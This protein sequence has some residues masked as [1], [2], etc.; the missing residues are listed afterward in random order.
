E[1]LHQFLQLI[2]KLDGLTLAHVRRLHADEIGALHAVW[3]FFSCLIE[4]VC[5]GNRTAN[6]QRPHRSTG[7][8]ALALG[9]AGGGVVCRWSNPL[10][11]G[12]SNWISAAP[13]PLVVAVGGIFVRLVRQRG[14]CAFRGRVGCFVS[15][16]EPDRSPRRDG[17]LP[18]R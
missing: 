10:S 15:S 4:K 3:V 18:P 17:D 16:H 8:Q 12:P 14:S 2:E 5:H 9:A 11:A 1:V 7:R 13:G 6:A